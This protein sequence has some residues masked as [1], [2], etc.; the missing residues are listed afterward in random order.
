MYSY[1]F[2]I[3]ISM[4]FSC[5]VAFNYQKKNILFVIVEVGPHV[6]SKEN[7]KIHKYHRLAP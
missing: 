6:L 2:C 5:W 1:I 3:H 7:D 4:V